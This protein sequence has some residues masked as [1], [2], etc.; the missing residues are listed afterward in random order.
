MLLGYGGGL[1]R[2]EAKFAVIPSVYTQICIEHQQFLLRKIYDQPKEL[3]LCQLFR[4]EE[5][6]G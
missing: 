5:G 6:F 1:M 2:F 3:I 4:N